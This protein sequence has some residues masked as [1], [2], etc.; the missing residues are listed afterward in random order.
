MQFSP[1]DAFGPSGFLSGVFSGDGGELSDVLFVQSLP[2]GGTGEAVWTDGA[3]LDPATGLPSL[4][5][6]A[7]GDILTVE[8]AEDEPLPF[9]VF[10]RASA[11]SL[12]AGAPRFRSLAPDP[13]GGF[14]DIS[15]FTRGLATDLFAAD[16]AEDGSGGCRWTYLGRHAGTSP[17]LCLRDGPLPPSGGR[18][19]LAADA[20]VD[21]DG[22][23][24]PDEMERLAFG[25]SPFLPDTD[26]DG[27][28]D[29]LEVAWGTNPL[30]AEAAAPQV[31]FSEAFEPPRVVHGP[32]DGQNGWSAT[33]GGGA[34]VVRGDVVYGGAGALELGGDIASHSVTGQSQVAW[35]DAYVH[36]DSGGDSFEA[37]PDA[38]AYFFFDGMGRPVMTDGDA[39][40]T[41]LSHSAANWRR[42]TRCTMALDHSARRWSLYVDGVLV[43]SGLAMRGDAPA[44]REVGLGGIGAADDVVV[45]T[46]RPRG[47]SSDGDSLPDEWEMERFGS[48]SRDGSADSDGDGMTD[49]EELAAGTDPM[50]PNGDADGDGL[51]DWWEVANGLNPFDAGNASP[52]AF[53]ESF[54]APGVVPGGIAGQNGWAASGPGVAEVCSNAVHSGEAALSLGGGASVEHAAASR[55]DIVWMDA[56]RTTL[57]G[58]DPADAP[59]DAFAVFGFDGEGRPLLSD[60]DGFSTNLSVRVGE[61]P[62]WARCTCR[63]DF[64]A[65]KWDFYLDGVV[66]AEGLAMRGTTSSIHAVGLTDGSGSL[67]DVYVGFARPEGLSS[68]GDSMPDEWEWRNFGDLSRDGLGDGDGDGLS[69]AEE[70]SAGTDP[71]SADTDGD[72]IPD[73]WE[74][75]NSLRPRD[76]SDAALD[77]DGDGLANLAEFLAGT[78]PHSPDT[79]GDG[80]PDGWEVSCGT[81]PL[82]SDAAADPDDDGLVNAEEMRFGTDPLAAD[83]DGD[84]VSDG[85]ERH[86]FFSD[87]AVADFSGIVVTN[88]VVPVAAIDEALGEWAVDGSSVVLLGRSGSLFF[89]N[90]LVMAD[91][92]LRQLRVPC[93]FSGKWN[94]DLVCKVDGVR[95]GAAALRASAEP[96][97]AEARFLTQWLA[98]GVHEVTVELRNF[99]NGASFECCGMAVCEMEGPDSDGNGCVDWLDARFRNLSVDRPGAVSSKVS[100]YCMRGVHASAVLPSASTDDGALPVRPLP[101]HGWWTDVPLDAGICKSVAVSYDGGAKAEVVSVQWAEFDVMS[102]GDV[103]V[104]RG[105]SL[106]LSMCGRNGIIEVDHAV[107]SPGGEAVPWR[108]EASGRHVVAGLCDGVRREVFVDV[109]ECSMPDEIPVWKGKSNAIRVA[110]TGFGHVSALWDYCASLASVS[111]SGSKCTCTLA[112]PPSADPVAFALEIGNP[113]ASVVAGAALRPFSAYYTLDGVYRVS[114]RLDDGTLVVENRLSA[115]NLAPGLEFRMTGNSGVCFEDGSGM[116]V[117]HP[118]DFDENGDCMYRFLVPDGVSNPCQ[119]LH[120]Y[121]DGREVSQ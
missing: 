108:F 26:G 45:S 25:T 15:L 55:A 99:A 95:I 46:V 52:A 109:V 20:A 23:G 16:F 111:V 101:S 118:E 83:T 38:S 1:F 75:G 68:D 11:Y 8:S 86:L 81:A 67:D 93:S 2:A 98:P 47:L 94:A 51:P 33:A 6:A 100:P 64:P 29:S 78:D 14:A 96:L 74:V 7:P 54:E 119:F 90:D 30:V 85:E 84:G 40:V 116:L 18:L 21:A 63:F 72:G 91:G 42:W 71:N 62:R 24:L 113:D 17:T 115:F 56:W 102:E 32:V 49:M 37:P 39:F 87:P 50:S 5:S 31:L 28:S 77:P 107:A 97:P 80:M 10:G 73:A 48:L 27:I 79:D 117:L 57:R 34:A 89:T 12:R 69:D 35:I 106:L 120:V 103:V 70:F 58:F 66:V 65:R 110:G 9:F 105:D 44:L 4:M 121:F 36:P 114:H 82:V 59:P 88:C 43:G 112:V 92:G 3:W 104:R 13:S 60:G 19:Y 22:D 61:V 76:P 41:N 53:R